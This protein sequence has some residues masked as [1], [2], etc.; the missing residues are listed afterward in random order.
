[1]VC[2]KV[3]RLLTLS[4]SS[5]RDRKQVIQLSLFEKTSLCVITFLRLVLI[6]KRKDL[7]AS[8]SW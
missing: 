1:M 2:S 4:V 5:H 8:Y 3:S 6:C 7:L